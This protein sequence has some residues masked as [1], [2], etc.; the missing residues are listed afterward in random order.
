[1]IYKRHDTPSYNLYKKQKPNTMWRKYVN[2]KYI[3]WQSAGNIKC[4]IT[5]N[6]ALVTVNFNA[7]EKKN[8]VHNQIMKIEESTFN[9]IHPPL[10]IIQSSQVDCW[11]NFFLLDYD[12]DDDEYEIKM[13]YKFR[14][15]SYDDMWC[16]VIWDSWKNN[17][18][19]WIFTLN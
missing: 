10:T 17:F 7:K 16:A 12:V 2:N 9:N 6:K 4:R 13:M 1:M 5:I 14:D 15:K 19:W 8:Y 3:M 11:D 18:F